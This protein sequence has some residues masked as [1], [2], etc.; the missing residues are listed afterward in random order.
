MRRYVYVHHKQTN[1]L[2]VES[3]NC[4]QRLL[5]W[6]YNCFNVFESTFQTRCCKISVNS[7]S[8]AREREIRENFVLS[9]SIHSFSL[10]TFF[11]IVSLIFLYIK[12]FPNSNCIPRVR[13]ASISLDKKISFSIKRLFSQLKCEERKK[14]IGRIIKCTNQMHWK[15]CTIC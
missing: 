10:S 2:N 13:G 3:V 14:E 5:R 7:K 9:L 4:Q 12:H 1:D 6:N 15:R 8:S 11:F